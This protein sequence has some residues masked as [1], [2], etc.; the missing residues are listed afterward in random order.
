MDRNLVVCSDQIDLGEETATR[1]LVRI[2]MDVTD[3][4]GVWNGTGVQCSIVSA[5]TP[6]VALLGHDMKCGGPRTLG[7]AGGAISQ[8][9]VD[10]RF[11]NRSLSGASR[12]GRQVTGGPGVVRMSWTVL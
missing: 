9:G 2:V 10:F 12:R 6:T 5:E 11:G 1:E 7:A 8:H 4:V 3:R